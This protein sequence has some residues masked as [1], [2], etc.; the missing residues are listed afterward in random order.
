MSIHRQSANQIVTAIKGNKLKANAVLQHQTD[1]IRYLNPKLNVIVAL[2][3]EHSDHSHGELAGLPI[4]L[5]DQIHFAGL[6]CTFG[7]EA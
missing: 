7:S 2:T 4:T 5:K 1:R 6:P 3:D